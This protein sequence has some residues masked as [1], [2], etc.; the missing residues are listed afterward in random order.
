MSAA[1]RVSSLPA[2]VTA[3]VTLR[4]AGLA[5]KKVSLDSPTVS[6]GRG[7]ENRILLLKDPKV[8]RYH[9][10]FRFEGGIWSVVNISQKNLV[11]VNGQSVKSQPL[12]NGDRIQIGDTE[13]EFH[14][15]GVA[16]V[17]RTQAV[18]PQAQPSLAPAPPPPTNSNAWTSRPRKPEG[19][20]ARFYGMLVIIG[21]VVAFIF[22]GEDPE[23]KKDS[24]RMGE[25]VLTDLIE[26]EK[27][28]RQLQTEMEKRG[29]DTAQYR[30]AEEHYLKGFRDYQQG[31]FSRAMQSFQAALSFY[32]KHDLARKYLVLARRKFDEIVRFHMN[33]GT[34]YRA[35]NNF[36]L[37]MAS[38]SQVM[39][40]VKDDRDP[41][42]REAKQY[43]DECNLRNAGR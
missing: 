37:C 16:Q 3:H 33:R 22:M 21:A 4:A 42:Y 12:Q 27:A 6:V 35:K 40:M 31:Q 8:S 1:A 14:L 10:E 28:V 9:C 39:I 36:R 17:E 2:Q 18:V 7:E 5:E 20:R 15:Q 24:L 13:I 43:Y 38:F 34:R 23:K 19:N 29:E 41:I 25:D 11:L 32:P 26:S 30:I